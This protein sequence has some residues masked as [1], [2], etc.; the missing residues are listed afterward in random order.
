MK[1][2]NKE[3]MALLDKYKG[4]IKE[5]LK[6]DGRLE[7]FY[8]LSVLRENLLEW[9]DFKKDGTLLQIGADF[10]A[11]TGLFAN[12]VGR[13]TVLDEEPENLEV[14]KL[15]FENQE[16]I[17][18]AVGDVVSFCEKQD[19]KFDYITLIGS[20]KAPYE[21]QIRAAKALLKPQGTLIVAACNRL[22]MKYF[23]GAIEDKNSVTKRQIAMLLPEGDFYY[24]MPDYRVPS[25]IYSD[26][27]LPKKGDLTKTLAIY[28]YP[29]YLSVDVGEYYDTVCEDGQFANFA[30]SFLVFWK[31]GE[32][33]DG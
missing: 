17:S 2:I 27:Y 9:Y 10:G 26:H 23:A 30:N 25:N 33:S 14:V 15:R 29:H 22:G 1:Q 13:V 4:N 7:T 8:A 3:I 12:K 19:E 31:K 28:D 5:A 32:Q 11:L 21:E 24:P 20:L 16:N 18:C 6:V